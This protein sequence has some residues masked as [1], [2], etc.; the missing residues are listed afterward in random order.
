MDWIP[1]AR[2]FILPT[3]RTSVVALAVVACFLYPVV[4]SLTPTLSLKYSLPSCLCQ[5]SNLVPFE[6]SYGVT[7][8]SD[9]LPHFSHIFFYPVLCKVQ[10]SRL[11]RVLFKSLHPVLPI[12]TCTI[13][14]KL[15]FTRSEILP[16]SSS[17]TIIVATYSTGRIK[18]YKPPFTSPTLVTVDMP[19]T[20]CEYGMPSAEVPTVDMRTPSI[21][22]RSSMPWSLG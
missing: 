15:A 7:H 16:F 19:Q 13:Q 10:P 2:S 20:S 11:H 9:A 21:S 4:P 5:W 3:A 12:E 1:Y 22:N 6:G 8:R 18:Q 17:F 14:Y